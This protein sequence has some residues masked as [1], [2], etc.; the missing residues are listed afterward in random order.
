MNNRLNI[1]S[2]PQFDSNSN[3][4]IDLNEL[5]NIAALQIEFELQSK[6]FTRKSQLLI[7]LIK[8]I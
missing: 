8:L 1:F 4:I 2:F 5:K 7:T 3:K 6:R